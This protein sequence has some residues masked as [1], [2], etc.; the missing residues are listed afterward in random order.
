M[1]ALAFMVEVVAEGAV[2]WEDAYREWQRA[3]QARDRVAVRMER[4]VTEATGGLSV[5]FQ[6]TL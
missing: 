3:A 5:A 2:R 6:T 4:K 1:D